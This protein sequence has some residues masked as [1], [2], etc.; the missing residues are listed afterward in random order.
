L[1]LQ[2][3]RRRFSQIG[4]VELEPPFLD[5]LKG[6]RGEVN[7]SSEHARSYLF[8]NEIEL[9]LRNFALRI[10]NAGLAHHNARLAH[11]DNKLGSSGA[12]QQEIEQGEQSIYRRGVFPPML[13]FAIAAFLCLLGAVLQ[14]TGYRWLGRRRLLFGILALLRGYLLAPMGPASLLWL[15]S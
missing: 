6:V 2:F 5:Y 12:Y 14:F 4:K 8:A 10:H 11:I 3:L 9:F 7:L 1:S 13:V 15:W